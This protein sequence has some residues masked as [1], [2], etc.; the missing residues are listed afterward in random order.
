[1]Y[2]CFVKG[3]IVVAHKHE[4]KLPIGPEDSLHWRTL[5][6]LDHEN[7]NRFIGVCRDGPQMLSIW[8]YWSRG[9]IDDV[10]VKYSSRIDGFFVFAFIEDMS[11]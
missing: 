1:L 4:S 8:K 5:R 9:S 3:K 7:L 2:T 10:I 6:H 11:H